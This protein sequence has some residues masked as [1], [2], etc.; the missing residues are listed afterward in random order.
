VAYYGDR[1]EICATQGQKSRLIE[2]RG[3]LVCLRCDCVNLWPKGLS[4]A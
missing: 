4:A 2:V 1:C 3:A